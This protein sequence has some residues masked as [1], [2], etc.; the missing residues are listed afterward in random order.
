MISVG[1]KVTIRKDLD[2]CGDYGIADFVYG[3]TEYLGKTATITRLDPINGLIYIDL[4]NEDYAWTV[5]MFEDKELTKYKKAFEILKPYID[6]P[7]LEDFVYHKE[8]NYYSAEVDEY[9]DDLETFKSYHYVLDKEEYELL[10]ELINND[11]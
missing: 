10:E 4:D 1:D 3:M 11:N 6:F 7:P 5:F 8:E 2:I 9:D